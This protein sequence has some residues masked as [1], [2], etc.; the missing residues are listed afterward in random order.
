M[1]S[2]WFRASWTLLLVA[3]RR[4]GR[5]VSAGSIDRWFSSFCAGAKPN[6]SRLDFIQRR[7]EEGSTLHSGVRNPFKMATVS[8][9]IAFGV[10]PENACNTVS[11]TVSSGLVEAMD[12]FLGRKS[13]SIGMGSQRST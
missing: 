11:H 3:H 4:A 6:V 8:A 10:R 12:R 2:F 7:R 9:G 1:L 13:R 5:R